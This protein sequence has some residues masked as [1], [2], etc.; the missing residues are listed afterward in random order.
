MTAGAIGAPALGAQLR[1]RLAERGV[2]GVLLCLIPAVAVLAMLFL[3]P[4]FYGL[5]I[6]FQPQQGGALANY[7]TF[8]GDPYLRQTIWYTM[9][10]ALPAAAVGVFGAFP[11]AYR[12]RRDFP[13]KGVLTILLLLPMTFGSVLLAEGMTQIFA[14][15][16]WVN[17]LLHEF[18]I[19]QVKFLYS[20]TGTFIALVLSILPFS[21]LILLGIFGGI[22]RNLEAAAAT[23]GA[24]RAA[25]FWRVLF[26]LMAPGLMTAFTLAVVE[27]FAVFPSAVVVGQPDSATH[28]LSIPLYQAVQQRSDYPAGAAIAMVMTVVE[29]CVLAILGLIRSRMYRGA[30]TSGKG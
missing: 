18:G 10:L 5:S 2:D 3:Y 24:G 30:A 20:Y 4:F 8:F 9:R 23:L 15:R 26:P 21:F 27:A 19:G 1:R 25:R 12:M 28:V 29:L 13:G 22:D 7:R 11:L 14:P 17:L 6:S 16:G